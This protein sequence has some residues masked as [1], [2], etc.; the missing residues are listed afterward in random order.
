MSGQ[1]I[2]NSSSLSLTNGSDSDPFYADSVDIVTNNKKDNNK[3][4]NNTS[5]YEHSISKE[6]SFKNIVIKNLSLAGSYQVII[7][8]GNGP[9]HMPLPLSRDYYIGISVPKDFDM[10]VK[11]LD[12]ASAEFTYGND[13]HYYTSDQEIH[14]HKIKNAMPGSSPIFAL[15]KNPEI[16]VYGKANLNEWNSGK[17][18]PIHL[19]GK[20]KAEIDHVNYYGITNSHA[21]DYLTYLKW[22]NSEENTTTSTLQVALPGTLKNGVVNWKEIFLGDSIAT[23]LLN[24]F[25][26]M[27]I[28][29]VWVLWPKIKPY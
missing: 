20:L 29:G 18:V 1:V 16:T 10:T 17:I 12:G 15:T 21:L 8:S 9:V 7:S 19:T 2:I 5:S 28:I 14:F 6:I 27:A 26:V 3:I 25:F 23:K 13:T 11:L 4:N 24:I 22:I